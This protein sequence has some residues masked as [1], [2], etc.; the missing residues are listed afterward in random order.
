MT[1]IIVTGGAGFIGSHICEAFLAQ[2]CHI[3][4]ID[5][6]DHYYDPAIKEKNIDCI[7]RHPALENGQSLFTLYR[8]DIRDDLALHD[9][10]RRHAGALVVHLAACA[11][12]RPSIE[13]PSLYY[14][15]NVMGTLNILNAMR[16]NGMKR[17]LFAS[18]S[19]IYG[20]NRQAVFT[21]DYPAMTPISPYAATKRSNELTCYTEHFL[22]GLSVVCL[23]FFTV[24]GPRQ[25]P[26]LA[27][28]KFTRAI[29]AGQPIE[30]YGDGTTTRDYTF[31]HDI[32]NG[33]MGAAD[34]LNSQD[35]AYEIVNL[36][37]GHSVTLTEM[38]A[39]IE[40]AIGKKA[41]IRYLPPQSGDVTRTSASIDKARRLFGYHPQTPFQEGVN[42]FIRWYHE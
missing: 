23:R 39:A 37:G 3:I 30:L 12:V 9:I 34:W 17:L 1:E 16:A 25:R 21:E 18:S 10:F 36:G 6:F 5:S 41:Q 26:D 27:I 20:E 13:R 15:V 22:H 24:Y 29:M 28:H 14:D 4:V 32:V 40:N 31:I 7:R 19:S 11:G 38:V 8:T 2:G 33:V 35:C 42:Q